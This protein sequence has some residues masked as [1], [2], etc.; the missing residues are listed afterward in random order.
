MQAMKGQLVKVRKSQEKMWGAIS[1]MGEELRG[2][3]EQK[4]M[5]QILGVRKRRPPLKTLRLRHLCLAK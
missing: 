2:G 4:R 5:T 1:Q 3:W